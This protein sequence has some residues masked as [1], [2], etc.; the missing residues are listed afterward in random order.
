MSA[1]LLLFDDLE[2]GQEWES[3]ERVVTDADIRIFAD[4]TGDRAPIHLDE[5]FAK[6]TVFQRRIAHGL[7]GLALTSGLTVGAPPVQTQAFVGLREWNFRAPI[8]IGDTIRVRTRVLEKELRGRGRRGLVVW[9]ITVT[10]QAGRVVQEGTS[11][12]LVER[13]ATARE[14]LPLVKNDGDSDPLAQ[15]G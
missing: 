12:T 6:T 10:N 13:S 7:L 8:F 5:E 15:A 4:L 14:I 3:P 1:H 11:T 2:V 9:G